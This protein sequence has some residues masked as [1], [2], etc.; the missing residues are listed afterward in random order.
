[1]DISKKKYITALTPFKRHLIF[2]FKFIFLD[3]LL[4]L[5]ILFYQSVYIVSF[6]SIHLV[7]IFFQ[8][9]QHLFA[10]FIFLKCLDQ[11]KKSINADPPSS[12][13]K[14]T[15][16]SSLY[17]FLFLFDG[18]YFTGKCISFIFL[19]LFLLT[20][21]SKYNSLSPTVQHIS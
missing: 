18:S 17:S 8:L 19:L 2:S 11:H 10:Y 7:P 6:G 16:V 13:L 15:T 9:I 12:H 5:E 1:M 21:Y 4:C 14:P 20:L 3:R